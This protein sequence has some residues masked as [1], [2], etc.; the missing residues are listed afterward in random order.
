MSEPWWCISGEDLLAMLREVAE[1]ADPDMV[2]AEHYVN[3]EHED[4]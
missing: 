4:V 1:G 2:Y 3:C